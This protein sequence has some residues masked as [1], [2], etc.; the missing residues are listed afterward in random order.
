MAS[1]FRQQLVKVVNRVVI[2]NLAPITL[3]REVL[4][5]DA[6]NL[7][8]AFVPIATY[9]IFSFVFSEREIIAH[10]SYCVGVIGSQV[11]RQVPRTYC[12]VRL[13]KRRRYIC[14]KRAE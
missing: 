3:A 12:V 6:G 1:V 4:K 9:V 5:L 14:E 11:W 13:A 2:K 10:N 8:G 7:V